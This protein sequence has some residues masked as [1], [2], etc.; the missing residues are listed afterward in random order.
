MSP[1]IP[2]GDEFGGEVED[3]IRIATL[4]E[5]GEGRLQVG[6]IFRETV[7]EGVSVRQEN[8]NPGLLRAN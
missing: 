4:L 5:P 2:V 8:G 7:E 3:A 1:K 6:V